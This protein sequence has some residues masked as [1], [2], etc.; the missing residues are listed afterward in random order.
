LEN[1]ALNDG[2]TLQYLVPLPDEKA[3]LL[4]IITQPELGEIPSNDNENIKI[5]VNRANQGVNID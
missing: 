5:A 1:E 4:E 2:Y 3:P